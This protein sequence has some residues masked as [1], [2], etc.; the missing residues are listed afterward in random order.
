MILKY[1]EKC[2]ECSFLPR[3]YGYFTFSLPSDPSS[4]IDNRVYPNTPQIDNRVYAEFEFLV[5]IYNPNRIEAH[6]DKVEARLFYPP[7][8]T[9]PNN[10]IGTV[11]IV[12]M[13]AAA[14]SVSDA[15]AIVSLTIERFTA[16]NLA[17]LYARGK[18]KVGVSADVEFGLRFRGRE[19]LPMPAATHQ[20]LEIDTSDPIDMTYCRCKNGK[21][22]TLL[23]DELKQEKDCG[24]KGGKGNIPGLRVK[25]RLGRWVKVEDYGKAEEGFPK[26]SSEPVK[27]PN[28]SL[29]DK[30]GDE[31]IE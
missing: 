12:N 27:E 1:D 23:G 18:L 30:E 8:S 15:F 20:T 24:G 3:T 2:D 5:S 11:K 9:A 4:Q 7:T 17:Q 26:T 31:I 28:H 10:Q 6:V 25:D 13:A 19:I 14:G 21:P 29:E 16:L 22:N